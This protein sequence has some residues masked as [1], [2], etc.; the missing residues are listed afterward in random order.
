MNATERPPDTCASLDQLTDQLLEITSS[1]PEKDVTGA[2]AMLDDTQQLLPDGSMLAETK[3]LIT[4]SQIRL[5]RA[6]ELIAQVRSLLIG[7]VESY[8]GGITNSPDAPVFRQGQ[9]PEPAPPYVPSAYIAT[10][11]EIPVTCPPQGE[12]PKHTSTVRLIDINC[13]HTEDTA[14]AIA[15]AITGS[16][17]GTVAIEI[18]GLGADMASLVEKQLSRLTNPSTTDRERAEITK[19]LGVNFTTALLDNLRHTAIQVRI[20]DSPG[21]APKHH[22][23]CDKAAEVESEALTCMRDL[24]VRGAIMK[25]AEHAELLGPSSHEREKV[26]AGQIAALARENAVNNDQRPIAVVKGINHF[27]TMSM[28]PGVIGLPDESATR[29]LH[30]D[31]CGNSWAINAARE[32]Q[33]KLA[34]QL[35]AARNLFV[36]YLSHLGP[37]IDTA[38][39]IALSMDERQA[40]HFMRSTIDATTQ[41][42]QGPEQKTQQIINVLYSWV[43]LLR[44]NDYETIWPGAM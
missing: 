22:K 9:N 23:D 5:A 26:M 33:P 15:K 43:R 20:I 3:G 14:P 7:Y 1:L 35:Q 29:Q 25:F 24:D 36:I 8:G 4:E 6:S 11:Y 34:I 44:P 41:P 17:C 19:S 32:G 21:T 16:G 40:E 2:I 31:V 38:R 10:G 12:S 30:I 18:S 28:I 37:D 27:R 42:G 39:Q 13:K